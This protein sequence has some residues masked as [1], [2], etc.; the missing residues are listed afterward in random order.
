MG[1]EKAVLVKTPECLTC[2]LSVIKTEMNEM[3][4]ATLSWHWTKVQNGD[5]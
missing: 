5:P 3:K 2:L 4:E 1:L